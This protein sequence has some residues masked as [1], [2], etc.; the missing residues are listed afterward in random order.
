[1]GKQSTAQQGTRKFVT[2]AAPPEIWRFTEEGE[3]VEGVFDGVIETDGGDD[4]V[5][6]NAVINLDDGKRIQIALNNTLSYYFQTVKRGTAVRLTWL[7]KKP[8]T[9]PKMGK[10]SKNAYKFESAA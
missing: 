8:Y 5:L 1:M 4:K 3:S 7:G 10:V 2:A 9:H 6:K